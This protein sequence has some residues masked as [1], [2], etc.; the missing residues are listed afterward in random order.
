MEGLDLREPLSPAQA[1][2]I[3]AAMDRYGFAV[4]V[5]RDQPLDDAQQ[6][7]FGS[8]FGHRRARHR[9]RRER[10]GLKSLLPYRA[11]HWC[12]LGMRRV[13]ALR[14]RA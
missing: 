8:R 1:G 3:E 10:Q 7:A 13:V 11:P 4:L 14:R 2:A 6:L 12:I 5:F 9:P